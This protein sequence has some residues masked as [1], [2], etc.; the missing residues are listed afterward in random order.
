[1]NNFIKA[2]LFSISA[3]LVATPAMAATHYQENAHHTT[4]HHSAPI[5]HV[6]HKQAIKHTPKK[7]IKKHSHSVK[8][9]PVHYVAKHHVKHH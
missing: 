1:M 6:Q 3:A 9:A 2:V 5:K 4:Q 7:T 8:K